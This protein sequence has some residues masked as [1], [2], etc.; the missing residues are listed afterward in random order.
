MPR[1]FWQTFPA[2]F[3]LAKL[4]LDFAG[5]IYLF[6]KLGEVE[7]FVAVENLASFEDLEQRLKMNQ[8]QFDLGM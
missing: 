5:L 7:T 1:K 3:W 4:H 6:S 2:V 8:R